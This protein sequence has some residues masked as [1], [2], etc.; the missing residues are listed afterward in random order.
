M[1]PLAHLTR[2]TDAPLETDS[3]EPAPERRVKGHPRWTTR[4]LA[5][6][7]GGRVLTGLWTCT[8]GSWRIVYDEWE[9]FTVL[10]GVALLTDAAGHTTTLI[11]GDSAVIEPGFRGVWETVEPL[12]KCFVIVLPA[13]EGA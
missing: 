12:T 1:P 6:H 9:Q 2:F 4:I 13:G 5:R 11:A 8:P 10:D 7:D 3:G